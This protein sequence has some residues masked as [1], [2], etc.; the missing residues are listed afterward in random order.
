[1]ASNFF[2]RHDALRVDRETTI[3]NIDPNPAHAVEKTSL[4][5]A[6]ISSGDATA[7]LSIDVST[8][9]PPTQSK[10]FDKSKE[11]NVASLTSKTKRVREATEV[12]GLWKKSSQ[13][14][15]LA[16]ITEFEEIMALVV[17]SSKSGQLFG[18]SSQS[19]PDYPWTREDFKLPKSRKDLFK[20]FQEIQKGYS[21][22]DQSDAL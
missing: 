4:V 12:E 10:K 16:T 9:V 11:K 21:T 3:S 17:C 8:E 1:M 20:L 5:A 15:R 22:I 18:E 7:T 6:P 14:S 2:K 19:L 13:G